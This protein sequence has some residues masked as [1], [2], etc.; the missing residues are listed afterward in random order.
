MVRE[1][2][3]Q[4]HVRI[5]RIGLH[6]DHL[7]EVGDRL[8]EPALL[9][10]DDA[11]VEKGV[12]VPRPGRDRQLEELDS[13]SVHPC[14]ANS[15]PREYRAS[16]DPKYCPHRFELAMLAID[17]LVVAVTLSEGGVRRS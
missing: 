6:A 2:Q 1:G 17:F 13:P 9:V 15:T 5:D 3:S 11:D 4:G 10:Q 14:R 7:A 16:P 8:G 12:G